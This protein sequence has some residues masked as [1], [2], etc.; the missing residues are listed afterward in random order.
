MNAQQAFERYISQS[1]AMINLTKRADGKYLMKS[2]RAAF[3][4][5][6]TVYEMGYRDCA[7]QQVSDFGQLQ[8]NN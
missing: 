7:L 2:V 3:A 4:E 5:F 6:K 8:G 1:G